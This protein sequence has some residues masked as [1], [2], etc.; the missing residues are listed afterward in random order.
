MLLLELLQYRQ[1]ILFRLP[2]Q[3]YED[4]TKAPF[5]WDGILLYTD[6]LLPFSQKR[7]HP[8]RIPFLLGKQLFRRHT[9]YRHKY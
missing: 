7:L 2:A 3:P 4:G 5:P 8:R 9:E 6:V 1:D